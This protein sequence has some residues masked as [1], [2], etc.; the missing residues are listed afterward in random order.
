[1]LTWNEQIRLQPRVATPGL[2]HD[3]IAQHVVVV[4]KPLCHVGPEHNKLQTNEMREKEMV[5]YQI[6]PR[7][8]RTEQTSNQRDNEVEQNK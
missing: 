2:V 1:V 8:C 5:Y 7:V 3:L 6:Q 4:R